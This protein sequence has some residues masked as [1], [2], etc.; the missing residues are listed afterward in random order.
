MPTGEPASTP[1][2][3]GGSVS[4]RM[5][6]GDYR[7]EATGIGGFDRF[8]WTVHPDGMLQLDYSYTLPSGGYDYHGVTFACPESKMLGMTL[9]SEGPYRVWKNRMRGAWLDSRFMIYK[10]TTPGRSWEYPEFKGY[11]ADLHW[12]VFDTHDGPIAVSSGT[13]DVFLRMYTPRSGYDPRN[14][15]PPFPEGDISF[16]HSIPPMGTKFLRADQLGPE[17]QPNE[18]DGTCSGTLYFRFGKP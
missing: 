6:N 4:G 9:L 5:E 18:A 12:A 16:M 2:V 10:N 8:T 7:I 13:S 17:G 14:T 15:A 11:F 1:A 3:S